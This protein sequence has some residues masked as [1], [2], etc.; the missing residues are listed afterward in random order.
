MELSAQ[1]QPIGEMVSPSKT[2]VK[3]AWWKECS[4]YQIYPSSF[5]DSNGDG[6]GD[7]PGI[8]EQL[9]YIKALNVDIVWLCPIYE[10]PRVDM[11][12]LSNKHFYQ[13]PDNLTGGQA[14]T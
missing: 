5:K 1:L 12:S 4:V 8:I 2:T 10:S 6:V 9:D 11:G 14:T 7:L 13:C 3:R